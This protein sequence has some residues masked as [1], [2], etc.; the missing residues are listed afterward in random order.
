MMD[1]QQDLHNPPPT[2]SLVAYYNS[3]FTHAIL[4]AANQKAAFRPHPS[5]HTLWVNFQCSPALAP[6]TVLT[7]AMKK[8]HAKQS[9]PWFKLAPRISIARLLHHSPA[10][11]DARC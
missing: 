4:L 3:V 11:L 7:A 5:A 6:T 10:S 8:R 1:S 2:T 9:V